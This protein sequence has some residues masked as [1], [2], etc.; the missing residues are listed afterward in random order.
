MAGRHG[1]LDKQIADLTATKR[2]RSRQRVAVRDESRV[3]RIGCQ[4]DDHDDRRVDRPS[5][6]PG[7][8]VGRALVP[9]HLALEAA[10]V[11]QLSLDLD[12]KQA[13]GYRVESQE[14][15]PSSQPAVNDLTFDST[16]VP[17]ALERAPG[18][19]H[20]A[21]MCRVALVRAP[22]HGLAAA[23]R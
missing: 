7:H 11:A 1:T 17:S 4:E 2:K 18:R 8:G 23:G 19:R 6:R 16:H 14:V 10:E 21:R 13:P 9:A 5:K 20:A 3:V 12:N 22:D 15:D